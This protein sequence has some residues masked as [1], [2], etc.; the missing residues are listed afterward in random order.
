MKKIARIFS[1]LLAYLKEDYYE[2]EI[3]TPPQMMIP[4]KKRKKK[5][6][7]QITRKLTWDI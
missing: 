4:K 2:S 6:C 1:K 5:K 3:T 7:K